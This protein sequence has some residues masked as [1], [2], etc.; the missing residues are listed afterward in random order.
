MTLTEA[1][2]RL[3][4]RAGTNVRVVLRRGN[5]SFDATVTR[6]TVRA[7]QPDRGMLASAQSP[8]QHADHGL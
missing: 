2:E 7:G 5:D 4:G 1:V 6:A 8:P 3:R